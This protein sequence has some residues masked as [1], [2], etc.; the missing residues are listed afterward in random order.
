MG[1]IG[2]TD[3]DIVLGRGVAGIKGSEFIFQLLTFMK[4]SNYWNKYSSG[5]T[6]ESINA[7]DIYKACVIIPDEA[8]QAEIARFF[9]TLDSLIAAAERKVSFLKK[10]KQAYL[11][12][13]FI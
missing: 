8:E 2:K 3:F 7:N 5:S 1:D 4:I 13:M 12:K 11:Q 6:F 9:Q 10:K